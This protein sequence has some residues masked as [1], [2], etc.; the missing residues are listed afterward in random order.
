[1]G[2]SGEGPS[3][4]RPWQWAGSFLWAGF[5]TL[6]GV[7]SAI[8]PTDTTGVAG[9]IVLAVAFGVA[10]MLPFWVRWWRQGREARSTRRARRDAVRREREARAEHERLERLPERLRDDWRRLEAA[11]DMVLRFADEGWVEPAAVAEVGT[12]L[13]RLERL[14]AADRETDELGGTASTALDDQVRQ[15]TELLVAL[16]DEAIDHQATLASDEPVPATLAEARERLALTRQAYEELAWPSDARRRRARG[17][18]GGA[19]RTRRGRQYPS[20]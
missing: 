9:A 4:W 2:S 11:H 13:E 17:R 20:A 10:P 12:L 3:R 18:A 15:L 6:G 5:W 7:Q 14:V 19:E 16:A 1:M 8:D